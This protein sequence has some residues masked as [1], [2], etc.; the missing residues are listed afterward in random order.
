MAAVDGQLHPLNPADSDRYSKYQSHGRLTPVVPFNRHHMYL[1]N[2]IFFST[3]FDG[4]GH[5]KEF[6]GEEAGHV[7]A[8]SAIVTCERIVIG[9][10]E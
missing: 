8:V 7:A 3:G 5:F 1:W 10:H 4:R 6:G 9:V 2:N